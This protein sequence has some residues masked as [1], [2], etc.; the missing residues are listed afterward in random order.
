MA[1]VRGTRNY[2]KSEDDSN[3]DS[4]TSLRRIGKS[5]SDLIWAS[6]LLL[7]IRGSPTKQR[8]GGIPCPFRHFTAST[9][10][11]ETLSQAAASGNRTHT[12]VWVNNRAESRITEWNENSSEFLLRRRRNL[13]LYR[14]TAFSGSLFAK[15]GDFFL[16]SNNP[17]LHPRSKNKSSKTLVTPLKLGV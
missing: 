6:P 16:L 9:G 14:P 13:I 5:M 10:S 11:P 17:Y 8:A 7:V 4:C 15:P 3:R 2:A 1:S 12:S